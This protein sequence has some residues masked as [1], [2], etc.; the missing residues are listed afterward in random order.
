[1]LTREQGTLSKNRE[2]YDGN[3]QPAAA[4][5]RKET[6]MAN[7]C[8]GRCSSYS[9]FLLLLLFFIFLFLVSLL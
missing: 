6:A 2:A 4:V 9:A 1:M 7:F 3:G 8:F 5:D